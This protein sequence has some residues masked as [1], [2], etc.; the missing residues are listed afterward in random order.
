MSKDFCRICG[1]KPNC[2][3]IC[4]EL[5]IHLKKGIEI[6][7][8]EQLL[9]NDYIDIEFDQSYLLKNIATPPLDETII[10]M[11]FKGRMKQSK[12]ANKLRCH[13]SYVTKCI[14]KYGVL[15]NQKKAEIAVSDPY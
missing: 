12:I 2:V 9:S 11:F 8:Q 13:H 5:E 10:N 14:N 1:K 6:E 15:L 7:G 3:K 4:N